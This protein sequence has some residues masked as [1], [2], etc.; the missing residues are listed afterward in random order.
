MS[1]AGRRV[2]LN[3]ELGR[4]PTARSFRRPGV[5][6]TLDVEEWRRTQLICLESHFVAYPIYFDTLR[7]REVA[8]DWTATGELAGRLAPT[9][10]SRGAFRNCGQ[11]VPVGCLGEVHS[12]EASAPRRY[13][14]RLSHE[15]RAGKPS[16]RRRH[17]R[18][19]SSQVR[20]RAKFW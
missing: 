2:P 3:P 10:C 14:L 20:P 19:L 7:L 5:R 18:P 6:S 13:R 4:C 8:L 1:G 16:L 11:P 12:T 15:G 9:E 17:H